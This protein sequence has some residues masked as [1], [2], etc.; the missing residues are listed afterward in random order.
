MDVQVCMYIVCLCC[1]TPSS[2]RRHV[3]ILPS[4]DVAIRD[5]TVEESELG[6]SL[7]SAVA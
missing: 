4:L 1:Y 3:P 6:L 5:V 7:L 2:R